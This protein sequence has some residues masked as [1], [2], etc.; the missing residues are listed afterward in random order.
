MTALDDLK[1]AAEAMLPRLRARAEECERLRRVPDETIREFRQ[2]GFIRTLQPARFGGLELDYGTP[3]VELASI[4][5]RGCGSS[6]WVATVLASHGWIM[7]MFPP[8]AQ[9]AV[10]GSEPDTVVGTAFTADSGMA[11]PVDGGFWLEGRW[12]FSSGVHAANWIILGAPVP[13]QVGRPRWCLLP[14]RDWEIVDVWHA[15]GLRGTGSNDVLVKGAFVPANFTLDPNTVDGRATPGSQVNDGYIYRLPLNGCFPFNIAPPAIGV[16][17]GAVESFV[18]LTATRPDRANQPAKQLRVAESAAEVDAA[19]ALLREDAR[20]IAA[21]GATGLPPAFQ[22]K[23][24]RDLSFA[25]GLCLRA[26]DRL[27]AALGG[28]GMDDSTPVQRACR[29]IHAISNHIAV[30]W[31]MAGLRYG[32]VALGLEANG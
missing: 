16:A 4:L 22:A 27:A 9:E 2:A 25:A 24:G 31:D 3:Q 28:H 32:R 26:V 17:R 30:S 5:G 15:A 13:G 6:A 12:K 21:F 1:S 20:Q 18:A 14:K 29:D 10:W 11:K 8:E 23:L 7:G 19:E